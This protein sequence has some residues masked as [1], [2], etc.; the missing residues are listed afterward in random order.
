MCI[1]SKT[2]GLVMIV[3]QEILEMPKTNNS[4]EILLDDGQVVLVQC[5]KFN[6]NCDLSKLCKARSNLLR[7]GVSGTNRKK[8]VL[9][10]PRQVMI[11]TPDAHFSDT[12]MFNTVVA[13][14]KN[15][16]AQ[17]AQKQK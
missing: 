15:C 9:A 16:I 11:W 6:K 3:S 7:C 2:K 12:R 17:Q 5:A 13:A 4:V 8:D 14:C 1:V 10:M